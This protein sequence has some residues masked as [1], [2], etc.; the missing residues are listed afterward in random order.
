VSLCSKKQI[1]SVPW[2]KIVYMQSHITL[3]S[4]LSRREISH[5]HLASWEEMKRSDVW[6]EKKDHRRLHNE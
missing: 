6:K 1:F 4:F 5:E 2:S 3:S